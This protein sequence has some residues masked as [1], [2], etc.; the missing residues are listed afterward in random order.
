MDNVKA[1]VKGFSLDAVSNAFEKV[2]VTISGWEM[3]AM[4][5]ITRVVDGAMN[6]AQNMARSFF[7]APVSQGFEEYGLKMN[8]IQTMLLGSQA[9]D[10][11]VNLEKVNKT[12]DELNEYAD[13]TIYSFSD[14]T[15]NVGKFINAGIKLDDAKAAIMGISNWAAVAGANSQQA[16]HAMY[17]LSQALATGYIQR[18]DW[19]SIENAQMNSVEFMQE[20]LT[21]AQE[22]GTVVKEGNLYVARTQDSAGRGMKEAINAQQMFTQ[23]LQYQWL[24]TEVLTKTLQRY[25]DETTE[26]GK[27]AYAAAK[28][29]KTFSQL[30]ETLKEA[31]GSGWA[32]TW[33]LIFGN[34]DEA[35]K[36]WTE[37]SDAVGG[38]I[39]KQAD[40]RNNVLK[41]WA[42]AGGR[43]ALFRDL[44]NIFNDL[45]QVIKPIGEA[46]TEIFGKFSAAKLLAFNR[47]LY[48]LSF[49]LQP[50]RE[51]ILEIKDVFKSLFQFVKSTTEPL[52]RAWKEAFPAGTLMSF[53][54][55]FTSLIGN[56][57]KSI[58]DAFNA[59]TDNGEVIHNV[60]F[61]V[62]SVLRTG[63]NI[64]TF[65]FSIIKSIIKITAPIATFLGKIIGY[66]V[67]I[68]TEI[69]SLIFKSSAIRDSIVKITNSINK[70]VNPLKE[71]LLYAFA[72][73]QPHLDRFK[74][75]AL[76]GAKWLGD[77]I[78]KG[79]QFLADKIEKLVGKIKDFTASFS[80]SKEG[81]EATKN[82]LDEYKN[83]V[84]DVSN[85][86][87]DSIKKNEVVSNIWNG[88][89][90]FLSN[91]WNGIKTSFPIYG[92]GVKTCFQKF[93]NMYKKLWISSKN[94]SPM[95]MKKSEKMGSLLQRE[96]VL[97]L[98]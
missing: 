30:M 69:G 26:L 82:K 57:I 9:I 31:V 22:V 32:Q 51:E 94:D 93:K 2:K 15:E 23:G 67:N 14:M 83:K 1:S 29:V 18:I 58:T 48:S 95:L 5:A 34:F 84:T 42:E 75:W 24:T 39:N 43:T 13:K 98:L 16:S 8:S 70:L 72:L 63:I 78:A 19:K 87:V 53:V 10:P 4:A 50:T 52:F 80:F 62:F 89:K 41:L 21:I 45:M 27:K 12:L 36:L 66:I 76:T 96:K 86:V 91:A 65:L 28:D 88:I 6:A 79:I 64:L 55:N 81:I 25:S 40:A 60:A 59:L 38:F 7:V 11:S 97:D 46:F 73:L 61:T 47:E 68:V 49:V 92:M 37:I 17:N 85:A 33:E 74:E 35:K 44:K 54:R 90:S 71:G 3:V 20:A 56:V 77:N